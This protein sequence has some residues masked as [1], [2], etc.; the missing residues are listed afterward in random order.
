MTSEDIEVDI[1]LH[2]TAAPTKAH[3]N[4]HLKFEEGSVTIFGFP[5]IVKGD[6]P[7]FVKFPSKKGTS[8]DKYFPVADADGEIRTAICEAILAAYNK[9]TEA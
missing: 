9:A 2:D 5:V 6:K 4:V 3:A 1:Q 7:A 8:P